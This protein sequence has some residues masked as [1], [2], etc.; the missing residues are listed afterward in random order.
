MIRKN[1]ITFFVFFVLVVGIL[2]AIRSNRNII[3]HHD[4]FTEA[5]GEYA[6]RYHAMIRVVGMMT[7]K[8]FEYVARNAFDSRR[9]S[10]RCYV[11]ELESDGSQPEYKLRNVEAKSMDDI[12]DALDEIEEYGQR[13]K[14]TEKIIQKSVADQ[15]FETKT[16]EEKIRTE[17]CTYDIY[18]ERAKEFEETLKELAEPRDVEVSMK[19][20]PKKNHNVGWPRKD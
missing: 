10:I 18:P 2:F 16:D 6:V 12:Q 8:T 5:D 19:G 4:D 11:L 13:P 15:N 9:Q 14:Q 1:I 17:F 20:R 3:I 7:K